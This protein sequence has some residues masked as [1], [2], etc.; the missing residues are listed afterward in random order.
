MGIFKGYFF[1][2][3]GFKLYID[4][5]KSKT[6][7]KLLISKKGYSYETFVSY[8]E[9]KSKTKEQLFDFVFDKLKDRITYLGYISKKNNEMDLHSIFL[10]KLGLKK[11]YLKWIM[12]KPHYASSIRLNDTVSL[13]IIKL[14]IKMNK[15]IKMLRTKVLSRN[16]VRVDFTRGEYTYT[17]FITKD[18]YFNMTLNELYDLVLP[19]DGNKYEGYIIRVKKVS[20][21]KRLFGML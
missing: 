20:F 3:D 9:F 16:S 7:V 19:K 13:S 5:N 6:F 14:N 4:I 18:E 15:L 2:V 1:K 11:L 21:L 8:E 17:K 12:L 10:K